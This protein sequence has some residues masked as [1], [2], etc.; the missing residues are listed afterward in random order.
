MFS[1]EKCALPDNALLIN[2]ARDDTY[3]DCYRTDVF[4]VV[5]HAEFVS[6]FYST[7]LFRIERLILRWAVSKPSTDADVKLLA[8]GKIDKFAAWYVEGRIEDQILMCDFRNRTRSWLMVSP[9]HENGGSRTQL[10]FGSAVVPIGNSKSEK[11]SFGPSFRALIGFHKIYSVALLHSA[12][13]LLN[14]R[15]R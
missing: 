3:T 8:E 10:Y 5:S 6:A 12:K 11:S 1:I 9:L 15:N 2:Y 13:S 4:G 14:A 7:L